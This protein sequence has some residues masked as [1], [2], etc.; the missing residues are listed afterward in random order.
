MLVWLLCTFLCSCSYLPYVC[1]WQ[2][3]PL[4]GLSV[5]V[6]LFAVSLY[7][8]HI[9][10]IC[11]QLKDLSIYL[12]IYVHHVRKKVWSISGI[13]SSNTDRFLKFFH[14]YNL[15]K[16]CNKAIVKY[17]TTPPTRHYTT[18]WN[19]DVRK[20]VCPVPCGSLTERQTR[21]N[22]D[23]SLPAAAFFNE[24][25]LLSLLL[26]THCINFR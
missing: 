1:C 15:Q 17:P 5:L 2:S 11:A 12:S 22:P 19:I 3:V 25:C 26:L 24:T 20:L 8:V 6:L 21:Q 23:V 7:Y 14:C 16:I 18:L 10:L 4:V 9:R 13:T